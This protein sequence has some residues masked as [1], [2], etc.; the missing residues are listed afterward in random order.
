MRSIWDSWEKVITT[1]LTK[2]WRKLVPSF[3]DDFMGFKTSVEEVAADV[4]KTTRGL[5]LEVRM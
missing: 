2:L 3:T 5:D 1:T 4:V